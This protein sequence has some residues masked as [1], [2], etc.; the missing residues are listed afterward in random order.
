MRIRSS[1]IFISACLFYI[2]KTHNYLECKASENDYNI[3]ALK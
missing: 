2:L 3:D 1:I